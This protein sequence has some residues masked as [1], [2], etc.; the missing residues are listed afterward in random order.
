MRKQQRIDAYLGALGVVS[1]RQ[2]LAFF[3]DYEVKVNGEVCN[4]RSFVIY[5]WDCITRWDHSVVV[6][7]SVT[8]L[9]NKLA[10]YVSSDEDV[11]GY[12]SYKRL[13]DDC[14]YKNMLHVAGRLDVDTTGLLLC[15]SDGKLAHRIISPKHKCRKT[16]SVLP[17]M[18][19]TQAMVDALIAGVCLDDGSRTLP[20][21]VPQWSF[22]HLLLSIHEGK[23]HQVKRMLQ[24]VWN[25]VHSLHRI[26]VGPYTCEGIAPGSWRLVQPDEIV[27]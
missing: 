18:P 19:M 22:D 17:N 1:R 14:V 6:Y 21:H 27:L 23:F 2:A 25:S 7:F 24:A 12:P 20:A 5:E 8:I 9:L 4:D 13:L 10:W 26:S 3:K 11:A 16:Y 15:T